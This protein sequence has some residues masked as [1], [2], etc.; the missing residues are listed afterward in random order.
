MAR[1]SA[2]RPRSPPDRLRTGRSSRSSNSRRRAISMTMGALRTAGRRCSAYSRLPRTVRCGNRRAS[3]KTRPMPRAWAGTRTALRVSS[4]T[5]SCRVTPPASRRYRPAIVAS[6][7]DLP[8]PD[9]P[10]TTV[11]P[12]AATSRSASSRNAPLRT[13]TSRSF[14]VTPR[15]SGAPS[16]AASRRARGR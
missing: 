15:A 8:E 3:W 6:R 13:T 1:A 5:R 16:A 10:K 14:S 11:T 7:L 4:S 12:S 2:T 9:G